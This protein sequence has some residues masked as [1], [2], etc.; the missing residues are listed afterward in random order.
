MTIP[1]ALAGNHSLEPLPFAASSLRGLSEPLITSHHQNNYGGAVRNLNRT[2]RE[3][4]QITSD[5]PPLVVVA[6]R[7]RELLFRNSKGLH[8]AYFGNLGGDGQ[9]SGGIDGALAQA[10]GSIAAWETHF[11]TT[12]L[13]LGGGSGWVVLALELETGALRTVGMASHKEALSLSSPLLVMDMYEHSYHMDFGAAAARYIDAFFANINWEE[14]NRRFEAAQR[15]SQSLRQ[16][17]V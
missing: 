9:R 2:E 17:P 16:S 3:L 10:Y 15:V 12:G 11:R 1:L 8:E 6:L 7:D 4:S 14:V 5:T 13:G